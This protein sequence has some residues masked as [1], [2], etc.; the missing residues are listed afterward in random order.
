MKSP[1]MPANRTGKTQFRTRLGFDPIAGNNAI[2]RR[3]S[4][5][6]IVASN[7]NI[8]ASSKKD[9]MMQIAALIDRAQKGDIVKQRPSREVESSI[10]DARNQILMAAAQ[11]DQEAFQAVGEIIGDEIRLSMNREGFARRL[12]T[13]KALKQGEIGRLRV[14]QKDV[15]AWYVTENATIVASQVR[16]PWVFPKDFYISARVLIEDLEILSSTGDL[17]QEKL[18]DGLE[19]MMVV[20]DRIFWNLA[21]HAATTVNDHYMFSTL[22]PKIWAEV[23]HQIKFD[24]AA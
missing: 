6:P 12:L 3:G 17:L 9:L 1:Y 15:S 8:N 7:G 10:V 23:K 14:R 2:A 21:R 18:D 24:M 20:E 22:T 19:Q 4:K 13:Y 11:G 16:Q 5:E